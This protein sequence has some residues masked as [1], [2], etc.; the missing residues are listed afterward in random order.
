MTRTT[1][2]TIVLS[3]LLAT[4]VSAQEKLG[5]GAPTPSYR[6]GWTFTPTF[7]FAETY[8]DNISLFGQNTAEQQN[9]DY[10]STIFPGADLHYGGR[11]TMFDGGYSGSFLNYSTF[12]VLNRWDQRARVEMRRQETARLKWG[13][14]ASLARM[15][16]TDLIEL[17]GIPYRHTGA[18]T[19]DM[20]GGFEY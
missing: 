3:A 13:G 7:G 12:S 18:K 8:D 17:G 20:R 19:T 6:G 2:I 10:I 15:P 1:P 14:R 9:D 5:S 16:S 11:H 4:A